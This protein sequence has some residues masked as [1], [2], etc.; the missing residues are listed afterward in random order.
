MIDVIAHR[1][2]PRDAV[3]NSLD[4]IRA[5]VRL[6]ADVVEVDVRRSRDGVPVLHHDRTYWRVAKIPLSVRS[7]PSRWATRIRLP[8]AARVPSLAHA[9]D[10]G[11]EAGIRFAL[12]TKDAGAAP[13]TLEVV[14]HRHAEHR[15]LF[16]SQ[17]EEA[18]RHYAAESSAETALLRDTFDAEAHSRLLDDAVAFGAGA[19]SVHPDAL[20]EG[21]VADARERQLSVYAWFQTP[22]PS[23]ARLAHVD[24]VVTD[25]PTQLRTQLDRS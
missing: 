10:V 17:H 25:W 12:D 16:W 21:F 23:A 3:E 9:L 18:V 14:R 20:T 4:G 13:A 15:V 7:V 11:L 22:E 2:C 5:A 19:V 8:D 24:G 6:G 1:T